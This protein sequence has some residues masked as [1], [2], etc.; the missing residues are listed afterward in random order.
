MEFAIDNEESK[1]ATGSL[2]DRKQGNQRQSIRVG[3]MEPTG[4]RAILAK[5]LGFQFKN[6]LRT[7]E[8]GTVG[9]AD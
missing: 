6:R 1:L 8:R 7:S 2:T 9:G 5:F 3:P 4:Q